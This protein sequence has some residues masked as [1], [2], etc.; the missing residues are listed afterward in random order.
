M[1]GTSVQNEY[2]CYYCPEKF[3][4][5]LDATKHLISAHGQKD[6]NTLQCMKAKQNNMF[7]A[8]RFK[9]FKALRK[10]MRENKC[11]LFSSDVNTIVSQNVI[12]GETDENSNES[13]HNFIGDFGDLNV[14]SLLSSEKE[15]IECTLAED[16]RSFV[17][18]LTIA[19]LPR[20][21]VDD[22]LDHTKQI[23]SRMSTMNKEILRTT[24]PTIDA[25]SVLDSTEGIVISHLNNYNTRFKRKKHYMKSP[26]YVAP[27]T[28]PVG[29][30]T[31]QYVSILDTLTGLFAN[32][33][34]RDEYFAYNTNH[35][36][37]EGVFERFCCG[38]NYRESNFFQHNKNA[39][40]IQI[41][42]DDVQLTSPLKT[43]PHKIC[44]IYFVVC[45]LPT[46]YISK[47]NNMY[48]VSL[49][50]SKLIDKHGYNFQLENLVSD[51][52]IL[53]TNGISIEDNNISFALR[54]TLVQ[55]SFDNLGGNT[56]FGFSKCFN[57]TYYCRICICPKNICKKTTVELADKIRTRQQFNDQILKIREWRDK[58]IKIESKNTLGIL[59]Y[60]VLNDLN[61]FHVIENRSQ[62]VMH[63]VYEGAMPLILEIFFKH[64]INNEIID[65][66]TISNKINSFNY[67]NLLKKIF[68]QHLF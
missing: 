39:I 44:A 15:S 16:I 26:F 13:W 4:D 21:L 34:F 19:H 51:L 20:D 22:I 38:Q 48:L 68:R 40:Q 1:E 10:H 52:K 58:G 17:D 36:C 57:S 23:V 42:Y 8:T 5:I 50:D 53:E 41:F 66:V 25:V 33:K 67:G 6:G 56:I 45:N 64:L 9:S 46:N 37:R 35:K 32:K 24:S 12:Q 7:C 27:K 49:C 62:D 18:K 43:R 59:N 60:S 30:G 65:E 11:K 31:F 54:G 47:L 14:E 3:R 63:D 2:E 29:D 55:V 61:Y 28:L